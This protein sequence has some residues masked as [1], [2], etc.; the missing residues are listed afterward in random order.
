[1]QGHCVKYDQ[2]ALL[3]QNAR[4]KGLRY[5]LRSGASYLHEALDVRSQPHALG[6]SEHRARAEESMAHGGER[7]GHRLA[8]ELPVTCTHTSSR[9]KVDAQFVKKMGAAATAK[10]SGRGGSGPGTPARRARRTVHCV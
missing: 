1:M 8:K 4:Q 10:S 2:V 6:V 9:Q 3:L 5:R 7:A